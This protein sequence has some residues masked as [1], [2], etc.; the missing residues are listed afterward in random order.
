MLSVILTISHSNKEL[1]SELAD[2]GA[3]QNPDRK[4]CESE[5][6]AAPDQK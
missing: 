5:E 4:K 1:L 2:V 6:G 3:G